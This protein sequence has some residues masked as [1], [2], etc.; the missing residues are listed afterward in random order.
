VASY[1]GAD[2][3]G[4]LSLE[5]LTDTG[6]GPNKGPD[7]GLCAAC[8]TG[9]IPFRFSLTWSGR[10]LPKERAALTPCVEDPLTHTAGD[11]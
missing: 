1:V 7:K 11:R 3:L 9:T 8:F 2:S 5:A 10:A 4:Y 6:A